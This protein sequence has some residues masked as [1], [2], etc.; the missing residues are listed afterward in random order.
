MAERI[1][2]ILAAEIQSAKEAQNRK[3]LAGLKDLARRVARA[4]ARGWFTGEQGISL[5]TPEQLVEARRFQPE[6]QAGLEKVGWNFLI[7]VKPRSIGQLLEDEIVKRKFDY[8]HPSEQMRNIIPAARQIAVN[9]SELFI[10]GSENL[11]ADDQDQ[12]IEDEVRKLRKKNLKKGTLE[13]I[14]FARDHASVYAQ[15]D[16]VYQQSFG[17]RKLIVDAFARTIDETYYD[18]RVGSSLAGVGRFFGDGLLYVDVWY[19][20]YG[21]PGVLGLPV[22]TP[23]GDR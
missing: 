11:S 22:A 14:D 23:A 7:E 1:Q 19:A 13:G 9:P 20:C 15:F 16:F 2:S 12:K 6:Q 17:G 8:V 3:R 10:P 21:D 18:A 4:E 5:P